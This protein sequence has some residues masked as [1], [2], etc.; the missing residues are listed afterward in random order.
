MKSILKTIL[1]LVLIGTV[2]FS[3][4]S[5]K[6]EPEQSQLTETPT[7]VKEFD[8]SNYGTYKGVFV[9]STGTIVINQ[10][11]STKTAV[12]TID[13]KEYTYTA[14]EAS[15]IGQVT[16]GLTF[17]NGE[18]SFDFNVGASGQEPNITNITI[19][20]HPNASIE[21]Q[22][23]K[24]DKIVK[25]YVGISTDDDGKTNSNTFNFCILGENLIGIAH[26][27]SGTALIVT[28]TVANNTITGI[29]EYIKG[30]VEANIKGTIDGEKAEG[31]WKNKD[32]DTGLF[33]TKRVL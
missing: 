2:T 21:I 20:G 27:D 7:A 9:G 30:T 24:S 31:T 6:D 1:A 8:S 17:K 19:V 10:N 22:K 25:C 32:N 12:L 5:D 18:S 4:S 15:S 33:K 13:G 28:G 23:E 26:N 14:T 29:V 16:T 3:C 11:N